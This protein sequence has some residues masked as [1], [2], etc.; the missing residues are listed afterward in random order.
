MKAR[1][2]DLATG[3]D[4]RQ[5]ITISIDGDAREMF[6]ELHEHDVSVDIKRWRRRRSLDANAYCWVLIDKLAAALGM[7][8]ADVYREMIREI[9]GVSETVC[10]RDRAVAQLIDGWRHN[11]LGWFAETVPS[12]IP[13]CTNVILY[14][15]SSIYD[16]AQMHALIDAV[17]QSC[18]AVGIETLPPHELAAL[19]AA[20]EGTK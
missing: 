5:R 4:G 13:G 19:E 9:G 15:G 11:G 20:W 8:K 14:Y 1:L 10:V 6:D 17:V 7:S 12:K 3:M 18:R 2:V 16:T